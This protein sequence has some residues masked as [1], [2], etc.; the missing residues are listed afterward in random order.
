MLG[1]LNKFFDSNKKEI[2]GFQPLVAKINGYEEEYKKLKDK[3]FPKKTQEFKD[4]IADGQKVMDL[5]P[6]ALALTR[7]AARRSLGLRHFDEQLM[8]AMT[9]AQGKI[10]EQKTG[11]G[12]TLTA[13]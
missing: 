7:E 3:D 12:K 1:L 6:E 5:L 4:R 11:E 13:V 10:A 8:G 9:L 2:A